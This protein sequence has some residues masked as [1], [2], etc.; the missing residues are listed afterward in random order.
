MI[1]TTFDHQV[2]ESLEFFEQQRDE[3][4]ACGGFIGAFYFEARS[5][6]RMH[7]EADTMHGIATGLIEESETCATKPAVEHHV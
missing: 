4:S 6:S 5:E 7:L 1:A 3:K 2:W